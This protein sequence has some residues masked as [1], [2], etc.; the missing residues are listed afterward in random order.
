MKDHVWKKLQ[1][2]IWNIWTLTGGTSILG[3]YGLYKMQVERQ[4]SLL[5]WILFACGVVIIALLLTIFKREDSNEEHEA[6]DMG[7]KQTFFGDGASIKHSSITGNAMYQILGRSKSA[8][9]APKSFTGEEKDMLAN[10]GE[11]LANA[12]MQFAGERDLARP[13]FSFAPHN[14]T[15]EERDKHSHEQHDMEEAH[16]RKTKTLYSTQFL[17][18]IAVFLDQAQETG[19]AIDDRLLHTYHHLAGPSP[20]QDVAREITVIASRI[21]RS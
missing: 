14:A 13:Q 10:K 2:I 19:I 15:E 1:K 5:I 12:L 7:P 9:F 3:L 8:S 16:L 21:R 6:K 20:I 18:Q 11:A 4:F 17:N